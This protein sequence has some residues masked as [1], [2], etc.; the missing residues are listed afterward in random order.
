[1]NAEMIFFWIAF[2]VA[3]GILYYR[4]VVTEFSF[5]K[6][7]GEVSLKVWRGI[8]VLLSAT[9]VLGGELAIDIFQ[10]PGVDAYASSPAKQLQWLEGAVIVIAIWAQ[11]LAFLDLG[12]SINLPGLETQSFQVFDQILEFSLKKY[13]QFPLWNPY[14]Y[15]GMPYIAHPMLHAFNP[16]ISLPVLIWGF[17][18]GFKIAV[19]LGFVIAGLG[20]WWLAKEAGLSS[21]SRVWVALMFAYCGVPAAKFLQ[22]QYLMV[23]ALGWIPFS[24]AAIIAATREKKGVYVCLAAAGLALLFFSGGIYYAYY[25]LYV[26]GLFTMISIFTGQR[27]PLRVGIAWGS[28]KILAAI[29]ALTLGLIA[30][31]ALPLLQYRDQYYKAVNL[32]L[33]DSRSVNDIVLDLTWPEPFR[34]G[35]YTDTLRPEEFWA[36]TGRWPLA[37]VILLPFILNVKNKRT[38]LFFLI[39]I[40]FTFAW[41]DVKDM[42]WRSVFQTVPFFYQ[43]RYPS[44]FIAMGAMALILIAGAGLDRLWTGLWKFV[45][46]KPGS[47]SHRAIGGL[48][49][50]AVLVFMVWSLNDLASTTRPILQLKGDRNSSQQVMDWLKKFDPGIYYVDAPTNWHLAVIGNEIHYRNIWDSI[51]VGL[52]LT[53]WTG[54]R[55]IEV[56][57]KYLVLHKDETP[58]GEAALIKVFDEVNIYKTSNQLPYAFTIDTHSLTTTSTTDPITAGET[59]PATGIVASINSMELVV[60][61]RSDRSLVLLSSFSPD[62]HLDIDGKPGK[63]YNAAGF[64]AA[65]TQAGTHHY[66]FTY[67]PVSFYVGLSISTVSL[68]TAIALL[69]TQAFRANARHQGL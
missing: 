58:S 14:F 61:S 63:I 67:Q 24:L 8:R 34:P 39:L 47:N 23:M 4:V 12:S 2:S 57:S 56:V 31:Q 29:G 52:D 27:R 38:L 21:V 66:L 42:P 6:K 15:N 62:W 36:Y 50:C 18:D 10:N 19:G 35:G 45:L 16:F 69:I 55:P 22:G 11:C 1:M 48:L 37:G 32:E 30:V 54:K 65:E 26:I 51:I 9:R 68:L 53:G 44:R 28:I 41:I 20:M 13:G 5:G 43:F 49:A 33:T 25:M 40:L 7:I 59:T 17:L 64:I 60:D 46:E 3:V